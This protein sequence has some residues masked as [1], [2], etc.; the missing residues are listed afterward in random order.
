[1]Y[2]LLR[3]S[4]E[5]SSDWECSLQYADAVTSERERILRWLSDI[6]SS[7][8]YNKAR[9]QHTPTTGNWLLEHKTYK[10]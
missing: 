3:I 8:N 2:L 4:R 6:D 7:S 9:K 10:Q 5:I 1:M